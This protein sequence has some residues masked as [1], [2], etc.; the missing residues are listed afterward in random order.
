M[1]WKEDWAELLAW[2][3]LFIMLAG[4]AIAWWPGWES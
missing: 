3:V 4:I 2:G 1:N